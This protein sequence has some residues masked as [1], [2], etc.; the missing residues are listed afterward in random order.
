MGQRRKARESALQIL[1]QL[2]FETAEPDQ[3]VRAHW[4]KKRVPET[5]KEYSRWLVHGI[6][7]HREELDE[8][9]QKIS[10]HWRIA[11]MGLID[12]N[13]LRL[14]AFELLYAKPTAPAIVINEAIEIAKK[15]SSPEA[16][17]FVNGILDALRKS[18]QAATQPGQEEEHAQPQT[19]EREAK[20]RRRT[21]DD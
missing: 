10:T 12:R 4:R 19:D 15:F 5:T 6:L 18:I 16:A 2:E 8:T 21:K 20:P 1:Y 17:T 11:R 9:I 14:A 13:I 3:A 7:E